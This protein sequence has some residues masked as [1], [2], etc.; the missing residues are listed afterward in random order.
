[1]RDRPPPSPAGRLLRRVRELAVP[2]LG[3][4]EVARRAG[5]DAGTLG[6]IERGYRYL[7]N[8]RVREVRGEPDVI[9]K[10]AWVL[11]ITPEQLQEPGGR[12][13][14]AEA[15]REILQNAP[16]RSGSVLRPPSRTED[17]KRMIVAIL[18][19]TDGEGQPLADEEKADMILK[20]LAYRDGEQDRAS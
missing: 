5:V 6:N 7:D 1:M 15:L 20:W 13:D 11:G 2:K 10:V 4:P 19:Q 3:R 12:D 8:G 14:A 16:P 18:Q 17:D 9:A